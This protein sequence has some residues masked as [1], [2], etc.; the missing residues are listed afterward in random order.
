MRETGKEKERDETSSRSSATASAPV[1]TGRAASRIR[2][3]A[4]L[5]SDRDA[6]KAYQRRAARIMPVSG[7]KPIIHAMQ[8]RCIVLSQAWARIL[9]RNHGVGFASTAGAPSP[10]AFASCCVPLRTCRALMPAGRRGA[11][12]KLWSPLRAEAANRRARGSRCNVPGLS[13]TSGPGA[14]ANATGDTAPA[15]ARAIST[16]QKNNKNPSPSLIVFPPEK[17]SLEDWGRP[18]KT[19]IRKTQ[20][21]SFSFTVSPCAREY[22][23]FSG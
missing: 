13:L 4:R 11:K 23:T 17:N 22:R 21:Q 19:I 20:I 6:E 3:I 14:V 16:K 8:R 7:N 2:L 18:R 1:H 10:F 12:A 15:L 9:S 5:S